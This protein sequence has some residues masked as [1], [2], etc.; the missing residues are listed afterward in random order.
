MVFP[1]QMRE[2]DP[3]IT[4]GQIRAARALL[5]WSQQ[6]LADKARLSRTAL[7]ELE[8]N[9]A[10]TRLST[11]V[12]IRSALEAAGIRFSIGEDGSVCVC[13]REPRPRTLQTS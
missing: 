10:D 3:M 12:K 4:P 8:R 5:G 7:A 6:T 1:A 9:G 11:I 2:W 13:Q